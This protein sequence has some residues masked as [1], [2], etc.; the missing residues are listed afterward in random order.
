MLEREP[1]LA[2]DLGRLV[3]AVTREDPGLLL[4]WRFEERCEAGEGVAGDGP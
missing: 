4:R 2:R 1:G 3:D